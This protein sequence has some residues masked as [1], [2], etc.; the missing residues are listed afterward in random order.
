MLM[1]AARTTH[2][3]EQNDT[4]IPTAELC[5]LSKDAHTAKQEFLISKSKPRPLL[6][7]LTGFTLQ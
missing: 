4:F 6:E 3:A 7:H 1:K 5:H 2:P